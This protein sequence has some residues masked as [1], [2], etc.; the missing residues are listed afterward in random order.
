MILQESITTAV[1]S[2]RANLL[3][4]L[5][6]TI[7]IVI[8]TASVIAMVGIGSSAQRAIDDSITNASARTLVVYPSRGRGKQKI[9]AAPLST[10]DADA[11]M[12]DKEI[13]WRIAPEIRGSK[14]L[15]Y[16]NESISIQVIGAREDYLSIL[17]YEI[18][19]GNFFTQR[20]DLARKRYAVL[21]SSVGAELKT[22]SKALV[23][24]DIDLGGVT[25]KVI[26]VVN[27]EGSFSSGIVAFNDLCLM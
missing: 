16:Q 23:G 27:S 11:L 4:S 22:S 3:R 21:G 12:K 5:L 19:D 10:S 25:F 17:G 20:D 15:K 8:G 6:T 26:G 7:A 2:I 9:S 18:D 14:S 13:N 1:D 24:K